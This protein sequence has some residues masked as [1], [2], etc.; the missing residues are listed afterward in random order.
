MTSQNMPGIAVLR[1]DGY[2]VPAS[3]GS[4]SRV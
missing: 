3:P 4:A 1:A 2:Q